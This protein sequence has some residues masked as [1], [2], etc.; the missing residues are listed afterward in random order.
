MTHLSAAA[1]NRDPRA[2]HDPDRFDV[3][4]P[5]L[6]QR[7]PRGQ[8]RAD[9]L[10]SGVAFGLVDGGQRG[11]LQLH[12]GGRAQGGVGFRG[13]RAIGSRDDAG[14]QQAEDGNQA[15]Q[16]RSHDGCNLVD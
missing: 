14:Q 9:G 12:H 16:D 13:Y 5:D 10:P 2:F 4:R 15:Q 6:C 8:Y 7:E 1:A 11:Q 3:E